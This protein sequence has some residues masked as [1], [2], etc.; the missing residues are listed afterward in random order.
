MHRSPP[1]VRLTRLSFRCDFRNKSC[2]LQDESLL[3][4]LYEQ[5]QVPCN[6][7]QQRVGGAPSVRPASV[8]LRCEVLL[9]RF[10]RYIP[11]MF[12]LLSFGPSVTLLLLSNREDADWQIQLR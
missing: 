3:I 1:G 6:K 8:R 4:K 11:S 5:I 2:G 10:S 12:H 9:M 7:H